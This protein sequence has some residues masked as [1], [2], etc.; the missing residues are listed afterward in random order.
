MLEEFWCMAFLATKGLRRAMSPAR[1]S[2]RG[3]RMPRRTGA[4]YIM[5]RDKEGMVV[6]ITDPLNVL[7]SFAWAFP[8][9]PGPIAP[10]Q[11]RV[12]THSHSRQKPR[13]V[14]ENALPHVCVEAIQEKLFRRSTTDLGFT[15]TLGCS[16]K[17]A[18]V[19]K[20]SRSGAQI[21]AAREPGWECLFRR[22]AWR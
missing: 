16:M 1:S 10:A 18:L 21:P 9:E 2:N 13:V 12:N 3:K 17:T 6:S 8:H 4:K 11:E 7:H 14:G 5:K 19:R 20:L 22:A 15:D